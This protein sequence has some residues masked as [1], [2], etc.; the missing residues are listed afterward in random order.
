MS[1][2]RVWT[3]AHHVFREGLR[4]RIIY[5]L[6]VYALAILGISPLLRDVALGAEQKILLDLGIA[7]MQFLGLVVA[8]FIGTNLIA[9][10]IDKRTIFILMAKPL[11]RSELIVGKQLGLSVLLSLVL[12]LMGLSYVAVLWLQGVNAPWAALL[13]AMGFIWIEWVVVVAAALLF[14]TFTTPI[15]ATLYTIAFYSVGHL[16]R[17]ILELGRVTRSEAVGRLSEALYLI[18]PDLDRLNLKNDAV[19]GSLPPASELWEHGFYG[20]IYAMLLLS[21]SILIFERRQF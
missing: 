6:P 8:I 14:G 11:R 5:L 4:D 10:E 9:K 19:Y 18:L 12:V 7:A 15:L 21:L 3:I 13:V 20:L 1:W 2:R 16:S 17:S